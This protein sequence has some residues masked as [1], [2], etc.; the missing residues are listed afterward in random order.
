MTES[1]SPPPGGARPALPWRPFAGGDL[2]ARDP[3]GATLHIS[4]PFAKPGWKAAVPGAFQR[5]GFSG[6][7][8]LYDGAWYEVRAVRSAGDRTLYEL[9]PW[10]ERWPIRAPLAYDAAECE[11]LA[12]AHSTTRR[13][14]ATTP[15]LALLAP[16][17]GLLPAR[18]Q[19]LWEERCGVPA[20]LA[21]TLSALLLLLPA[22]VFFAAGLGSRF[23]PH[24]ATTGADNQSS[25]FLAVADDWFPLSAYLLGES[26]WRLGSALLA[27][28]PCGS[29]LTVLPFRL[30]RTLRFRRPAAT[31]PAPAVVLRDE[32]RPANAD[33]SDLEVLSPLAK[34]HWGP[35][36]AVRYGGALYAFLEHDSAEREGHAVQRY[37][38]R[39]AEPY[40]VFRAVVDYD[41][42][43]P[44]R[45]AYAER[46][47]ARSTWVETF[48]P[49]WGLLDE[50]LQLG[51]AE[52]FHYDPRRSTLHGLLLLG[53]FAVPLAWIAIGRLVGPDGDAADLVV[54]FASGGLL[55]EDA[56]RGRALRRERITG[57]LLGYLLAPLARRLL[58]P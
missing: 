34:P 43:E 55:F 57:S 10:D 23:A 56:V 2:I 48:A 13:Q 20:S 47:A 24:L 16:V 53:A 5:P 22:V 7:P 54:L 4:S 12:A 44:Q 11:R 19:A 27:G 17:V 46:T 31:P 33:G 25:P 40:L 30:A 26:L 38:L 15:F 58:G 39:R 14:D 51:L 37:R 21:T 45:L 18:L 52:R 28:E 9:G 41:A 35:A 32:I 50:P 29:L 3:G 1:S 6:T 8:V 36:T 42:D 49:L